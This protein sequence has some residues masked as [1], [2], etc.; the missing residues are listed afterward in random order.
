MS[1]APKRLSLHCTTTYVKLDMSSPDLVV[2]TITKMVAALTPND[3][4]A[5]CRAYGVS[6]EHVVVDP[7]AVVCAVLKVC[8]CNLKCTHCEMYVQVT[9]LL[10][11]TCHTG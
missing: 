10:T 3:L 9:A 1:F 2:E 4:K 6:D 7:I 5:Y 8:M 11:H